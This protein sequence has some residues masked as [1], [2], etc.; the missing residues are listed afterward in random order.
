[1]VSR[2]IIWLLSFLSFIVY[3]VAATEIGP[4]L[5]EIRSEFMLNETMAGV[6]ASLQSLA[7]ILAILGGI[8][9]DFFGRARLVSFSLVLMGLGALA[10]SSAPHIWILGIALFIF[11]SGMGFFEA[12][13]NAFI[14]E[15]FQDKRGMAINLLHIGWN[16]GSTI[17]PLLAA[18]AIL[19]YGAWRFGY[20]SIAPFIIVLSVIMWILARGFS[21]NRGEK[22]RDYRSIDLKM[23]LKILP[24]MLIPFLIVAS[25]LG[26]TT[27]LPSILTD[28]GASIVEASL[29]V[30]LFWALSGVGRLVWAPFIDRLGYWRILVITGGCSTLLM[31]LT[32]LPLPTYI[33]MILW[34]CSGL[35]LG[36]AYPTTVAWITAIHPEIGGTLSGTLFAFATLG[37]FA[38]AIIIGALFDVFGSVIAQLFFPLPILAVALLSYLMRGIGNF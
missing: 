19:A 8:L 16:I 28:Q 4:A 21:H 20:L 3:A 26:V 23:V 13:V 9:S 33:R 34:A 25:Q 11:G 17:G 18:Y 12:S 10:I 32:V 31:L 24:L 38:S 1:M 2:R 35:I 29:T 36:P 22:S 6:L 5:S 27:W 30:G 7:G 37:S 15:V 14:S